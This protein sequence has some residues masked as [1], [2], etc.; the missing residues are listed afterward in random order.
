MLLL[1]VAITA[2][3]TAATTLIQERAQSDMQGRMFGLMGSMYSGFLLLGM[4]VFGPLADT[5]SLQLL[6]IFTGGALVA[7]A[8]LFGLI[9]GFRHQPAIT[10]QDASL[11]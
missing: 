11:Q 8:G 3:Q 9:P 2:A 7:L 5:V 4:S 10:Q 6:M 1:G